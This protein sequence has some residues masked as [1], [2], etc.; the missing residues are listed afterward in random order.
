MAA[1]KKSK[2]E[3]DMDCGGGAFAWE[4]SSGPF[5]VFLNVLEGFWIKESDWDG[6]DQV[7]LTTA[8]L[9]GKIIFTLGFQYYANKGNGDRET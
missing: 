2:N 8:N 4:C 6:V 5:N 3:A 9:Q 7:S 1:L